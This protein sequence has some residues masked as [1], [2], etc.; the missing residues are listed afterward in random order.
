MKI[1]T[2]DSAPYCESIFYR[3]TVGDTS[4]IYMD[5]RDDRSET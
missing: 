3:R 4:W 5:K 1:V 2:S